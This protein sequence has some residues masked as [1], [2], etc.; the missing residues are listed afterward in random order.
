MVD[1]AIIGAGPAG[2]SAAVNAAARNKSVALF[3]RG[4]E[5]SALWKAERVANHL[6][7]NGMSGAAMLDAYCAHAAALGITAQKGR[8]L[9]IMPMGDFFMLNAEGEMAEARTV[10]LAMGVQK[11]KKLKGEDELLGKG[12]SYCATCDG[13]LYRGRDVVVIGEIA[14]AEE[15][16]NFLAGICESVFYVPLYGAP[17]HL[18]EKIRVLDGKP[19]EICGAEFAEG[20]RIGGQII[21]C[22]GVFMIKEAAPLESLLF[23]LAAEKNAVAVNRLM[24]TNIAGVFA[25]GDCTGWPYQVSKA[26]G[27]GLIA[28][29]QAAR[30]IDRKA[31]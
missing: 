17:S 6:G 5:T 18:D 12:V 7:E 11:G 30:Y 20:V 25:C 3:G 10:I 27:E 15:D 26:I 2:L 1:I 24:E 22:G 29:Q 14:E 9:Q 28:A 19:T 21:E 4:R 16:A 8:V 13:M 23:G 31:E